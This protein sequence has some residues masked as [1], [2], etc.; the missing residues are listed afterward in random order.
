L[1][2]AARN[3]LQRSAYSEASRQVERGRKL[4]EALPESRESLRQELQLLLLLGRVLAATKGWAVGEVESV[5]VRAREICEQLGDTPRLLQS[6]WGLIGVTFV[7]ADF[8]KAQAIGGQVLSIAEEQRNPVYE[9]LGHMEV[10]GTAFHLGESN[11]DTMEHFR[12]AEALYKPRQHR[13]HIACFGVD[14]GLFSKSWATHYFWLAGYPDRARGMAEDT[15]RLARELGHPFTHGVALAYATMLHQFCRESERVGELGDT[16]ITLCTEHGFPYYLAWAEALRGWSKAAGGDCE[17]GVADLRHAIEALQAKAG[18][19]LSY[20]RFLL[21][22]VL[23]WSGCTGGALAAIDEA[24]ADIRKTGECWWEPEL[25]RLRGEVLACGA[26]G[27]LAEAEACFRKAIDVALGQQAKSLQ[28]RG[29]VSL[30]R[31][32]SRQGRRMEAQLL[33][34]PIYDWFTEGFDTRDLREAKL[35]LEEAQAPLP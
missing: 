24:F 25:H 35:L 23:L 19:R 30:G 20:Y 31:F 22:E 15:L 4:V 29:A 21:G 33:L 32:W 8:R 28:L 18:A 16:A 17:Q 1:E 7:G 34:A 5:F 2:Q 6:L 3:A 26:I 14:M 27:R 10:G 12:E 9:I 11:A 13:S